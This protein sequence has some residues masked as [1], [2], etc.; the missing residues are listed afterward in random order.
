MNF[1]RWLSVCVVLLLFR[2]VAAA[3]V[4]VR[5][6]VPADL[7]AGAR[8]GLDDVARFIAGLDPAPG[9]PLAPYAAT[10][11]WKNYAAQMN[12][13]WAQF[14]RLRLQPIRTWRTPA[15]S[16]VQPATLF[17]PFSGPDFVFAETFFPGANCF[18]LCGLEP[19]GD[20]PSMERI[21]PLSQTFGWVQN[22][23]KTVLDAG[24]FVTKDMRVDFSSSPLQGTLPVLCVMLARA[25]D[26]IVSIERTGDHAAIHYMRGTDGRTATVHYYCV[27]LRDDGLKKEGAA[28]VNFVKQS[29]PGAAYIKAASY[30]M[31]EQ[32]FSAI[33]DLLLSQCPVIVQDDSGIPLRFFIQDRWTLRLFGTYAPPLDIFKQY[34]QPDMA[35]LYQRTIA[36]PLGFGA[37]YHWDQRSANLIIFT[38]K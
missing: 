34:Y 37:G 1:N 30:L 20:P 7:P 22:T 3:P 18:I 28:F 31:H 8:A 21:L 25:G 15:M 11:E 19:V 10:A 13:R 6:A 26:R 12:E 5:R 32:D 16:S 36:A 24:Y 33:R 29:R 23:L 27:N 9:S 14:D 38:R 17:Y 4:E 35:A 2:T